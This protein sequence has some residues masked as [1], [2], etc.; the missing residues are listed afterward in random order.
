VGAILGPWV[1]GLLQQAYSGPTAIFLVIA[2]AALVAA[3]AMMLAKRENE[4]VCYGAVNGSNLEHR[5]ARLQTEVSPS[6][7][8]R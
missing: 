7:S 8:R 4:I 2:I 1:A 6:Q 3:V 5:S